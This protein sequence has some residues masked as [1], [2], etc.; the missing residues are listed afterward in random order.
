MTLRVDLS[1]GIVFE[2]GRKNAANPDKISFTASNEAPLNLRQFSQNS[3]VQEHCVEMVFTAFHPNRSTNM[4][5]KKKLIFVLTYK[6]TTV[7]APIF[8]RIRH[9]FNR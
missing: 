8:M 3:V 4:Q 6:S 5:I 9:R 1:Y 2:N 7:T